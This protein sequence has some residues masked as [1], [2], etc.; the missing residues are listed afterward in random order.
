MA[1]ICT[2]YIPTTG[3]VAWR[4]KST[5]SAELG[6]VAHLHAERAAFTRLPRSSVYLLVQNAYPCES[7]QAHFKGESLVG[8]SIVL[9]VEANEGSY[10]ADHF[11]NSAG[12]PNLNGSVPCV[13]HYHGGVATYVTITDVMAGRSDRPPAGFPRIPDLP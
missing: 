12:K 10:S 2:G 4:Q 11:T 3:N 7:C 13:I 9:K 8:H 6:S 5:S 1:I